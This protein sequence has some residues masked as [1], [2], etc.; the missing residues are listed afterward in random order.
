MSLAV[1]DEDTVNVEPL[2]VEGQHITPGV[3]RHAFHCPYC[4]VLCKQD[5]TLLYDDGNYKSRARRSRCT[6]CRKDAYWV[7]YGEAEPRRTRWLMVKP[8]LGGGPRPHAL[9]PDGPK[10]DYVEAQSVVNLSSRGAC[11][12]LRLG[13]E[14]LAEELEPGNHTLN[15]RIGRI[16][17][18][19]LPEPIQ[20]G[21]DALRVIGNNAVHPGELDLRDDT[22][23]A[24]A[25]F[26]V[27]NLIVEDRIAQPKKMSRL[28]DKLPTKA[29]EAIEKRDAPKELPAG[30]QQ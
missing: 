23:T 19:G 21:L 24:V 4:G 10:A 14:K 17:A 3:G 5:W 6:N 1:T 13:V 12:L 28:Y 18:K 11:A 30:E 15:D 20:Q 25:L 16:V 2:A 9:M 27:M 29:R 7:D 8:F 22:E 26:E